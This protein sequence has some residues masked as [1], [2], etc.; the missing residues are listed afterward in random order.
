MA[1][2][3]IGKVLEN[4]NKK[5]LLFVCKKICDTHRD[6]VLNLLK[7]TTLKQM[8]KATTYVVGPSP[9]YYIYNITPP[10]KTE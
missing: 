10:S 2:L 6:V 9:N 4:F 8:Q 1:H 5:K 3:R 7:E